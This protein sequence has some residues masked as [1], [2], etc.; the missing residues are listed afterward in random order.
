MSKSP[1]PELLRATFAPSQLVRLGVS[2]KRPLLVYAGH[3]W[4]ALLLLPTA[5][6]R[7]RTLT[8]QRRSEVVRTVRAEIAKRLY[9]HWRKRRKRPDSYN[10]TLG[11]GRLPKHRDKP[12]SGYSIDG[13]RYENGKVRK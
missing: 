11:I 8:D 12:F 4:Q 2:R 7:R 13:H 1:L 10:A 3:E 9:V 5:W 6:A